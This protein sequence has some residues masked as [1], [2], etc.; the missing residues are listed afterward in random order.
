MPKEDNRRCIVC[1]HGRGLLN[2]PVRAVCVHEVTHVRDRIDSNRRR[3]QERRGTR[4]AGRVGSAAAKAGGGGA[5]DCGVGLAQM[6]L[7]TLENSW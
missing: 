2:S 1:H 5:P 7:K 6:G 3:E 4:L